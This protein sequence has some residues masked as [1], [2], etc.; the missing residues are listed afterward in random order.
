[1]ECENLY[2]VLYTDGERQTQ[3]VPQAVDRLK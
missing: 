1:M 2:T 3:V